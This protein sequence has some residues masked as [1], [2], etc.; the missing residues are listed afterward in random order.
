MLNKKNIHIDFLPN[1]LKYQIQYF[2]LEPNYKLNGK[3]F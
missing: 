3:K 2:N 1:N